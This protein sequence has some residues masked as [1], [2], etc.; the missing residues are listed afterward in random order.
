MVAGSREGNLIDHSAPVT[1]RP[2]D[3]RTCHAVPHARPWHSTCHMPCRAQVDVDAQYLIMPRHMPCRAT[4]DAN[5][6]RAMP[7]RT[8]VDL[9]DKMRNL[10]RSGRVAK[11]PEAEQPEDKLEKLEEEEFVAVAAE[12]SD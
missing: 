12:Y 10:I 1:S 9:K 4:C 6:L 8:Q 2:P 5:P 3:H 11:P 7:C